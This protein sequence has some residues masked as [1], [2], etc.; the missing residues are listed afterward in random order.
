MLD[1]S[2]SLKA[3]VDGGEY[4]VRSQSLLALPLCFPS[5]QALLQEKLRDERVAVR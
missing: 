5:A 2:S 3:F 4:L 1:L